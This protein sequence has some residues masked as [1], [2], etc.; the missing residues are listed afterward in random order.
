M[1][2]ITISPVTRVEGHAG[3]KIFLNEQGEVDSAHFQVVELRGF[4]KFLVGAAIEEAPRITPRICGICPSA[5]H[6]AAA[7]ATDQIFGVEPPATG[8]KLRE[9]LNIG[10]F[11]HSH[12]L[13]FFM[14]AAPDF[15]LGYDAPAEERNV[16]GLARHSPEIAKKAIAVRKFGQRLTEA[17]GGKPIHPANALSGGMSAPLTE[18]KRAELVTMAD[19]AL[20]IAREG[21]DLARG[22]LDGVDT[23]VGAVETGFL[24]MTRHG[25]HTTYEGPVAVLGPDGGR[26]GSFSGEEYTN[27]IEEYSEDWSYL[28]FARLKGGDYYRVGPLARL[29]IVEKMG[30]EH[31]DAALAEYRE[32][33][34]TVTQATLAYHLARYIEFLTSCERAVEL[35]SDPGITGSDV[36]IPVEK[37]VNRRGIG[38]IEA[39]RGTLIHDYTV[40]E[41]GIIERCNL[42][43]ATCQ[44]N[45]A[46]D[47]GVEDMARRVVENGTLTEGAANRI[48]MIIRAYDPCISCATHAIGRMPLRIE[49]VRR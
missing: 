37:V 30:T 14:L 2:E 12:A 20:T 26:I 6:L 36:R 44:N 48:E 40:S 21:W 39:P 32:R 11:I 33:F 34:G 27:F 8:K 18:G 29:N 47:R 42:I 31:A 7:K 3:I 19:E 23:G 24:G 9:L 4:E 43:V 17:V 35:L 22:L 16:I 15:I 1:K 10:Q 38:I 5:H 45:Y 49:L 28:K 41:S 25:L 46:I 13:H